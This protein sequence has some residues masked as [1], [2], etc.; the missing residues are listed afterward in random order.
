[1]AESIAEY[2]EVLKG[3][4][5]E[6]LYVSNPTPWEVK[7]VFQH[8]TATSHVEASQVIQLALVQLENGTA[9][10]SSGIPYVKEAE[11]GNA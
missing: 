8:T 9:E 1:M 3:T 11:D 10:W 7:Y 2:A 4:P 5:Y 6:L